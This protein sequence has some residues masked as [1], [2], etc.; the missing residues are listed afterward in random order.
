MS[1][2]EKKNNKKVNQSSGFKKVVQK[3]GIT[4]KKDEAPSTI[5][6]VIH[7][8][9]EEVS[10]EL[11]SE[12]PQVRYLK[13]H[14]LYRQLQWGE[15]IVPELRLNGRWLERAGF[16]SEK[17]VSVTIMEGLLIIKPATDSSNG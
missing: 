2:T 1:I 9:L 15:S 12:Q 14:R 3:Q 13:L 6:K 4:T 7:P 17:Y 5:K 8:K 11:K 16:N 10:L